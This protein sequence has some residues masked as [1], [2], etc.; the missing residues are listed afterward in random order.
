[1]D[2]LERK[3]RIALRA[4]LVIAETRKSEILEEI[5]PD[6][7]PEMFRELC[8]ASLEED[9]A[10]AQMGYRTDNPFRGL[11]KALAHEDE[12]EV[13]RQCMMMSEEIQRKYGIYKALQEGDE[14][15]LVKAAY[16]AVK[17]FLET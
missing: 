3:K 11:S 5:G 4:K 7:S 14:S 10:L 8:Q 1:M 12:R 17:A 15:K 2:R 6:S 9:K 13:V 16:M